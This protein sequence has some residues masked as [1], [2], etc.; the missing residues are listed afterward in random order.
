MQRNYN[1]TSELCLVPKDYFKWEIFSQVALAINFPLLFV[2][3]TSFY[4]KQMIFKNGFYLEKKKSFNDQSI[5]ITS[6]LSFF[7]L[8]YLKI[9]LKHF[10]SI[11]KGI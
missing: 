1:Y 2:N 9:F 11:F 8:R 7:V 4:L 10:R 5:Q 3:N 6:A